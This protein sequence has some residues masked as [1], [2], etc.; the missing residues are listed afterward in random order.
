MRDLQ[1]YEDK[2][3][4]CSLYQDQLGQIVVFWEMK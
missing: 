4:S 1:L 2:I 3:A